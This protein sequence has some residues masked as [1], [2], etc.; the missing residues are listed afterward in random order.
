MLELSIKQL[1]AVD[2]KNFERKRSLTKF[3]QDI[4]SKIEDDYGVIV[5][6]L[7]NNSNSKDMEKM[8]KKIEKQKDKRQIRLYKDNYLNEINANA[9]PPIKTKS[10]NDINTVS[11]NN[12]QNEEEK[13]NMG[14]NNVDLSL[15]IP[16]KFH[17]IPHLTIYVAKLEI[18][19]QFNE[20]L[21]KIHSLAVN[22]YKEIFS[23]LNYVSV[24]K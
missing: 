16:E 14:C 18:M 1:F 19:K 8:L 6:C 17:E 23:T 20:N 24:F 4:F 10:N 12:I 11:V 13:Q 22:D 2:N 9:L 15:L 21:A 3:I 7:G 5:K